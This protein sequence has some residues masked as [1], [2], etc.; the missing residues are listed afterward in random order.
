MAGT[1]LITAANSSLA[2][3]AVQHLLTQYPD[4]TAVLTVRNATDADVN[5]QRL[6][7][8]IAKCPGSKTSIHQLD[9]ADLSAVHRFADTVAD[10]IVQ[11]SLP[12]LS[13]LVCNAYYWNLA[14]GLETTGDGYEKGIQVSHI[15]H[16]ALV[17]RLLGHFGPNGGRVVLLSSETHWQGKNGMEKYPPTI[18]DDLELLA[19]PAPDPT[20]DNRGRGFQ[21][22][23][24][25]KLAIVIWMYALNRHL[26][27]VSHSFDIPTERN[28]TWLITDRTRDYATS[29]LLLST[30]ALS[31]TRALCEPIRPTCWSCCL[32]SSS[33]H[34]GLCFALWIQ[35][36][37]LPP[38]LEST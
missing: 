16:A 29:R 30:L 32:N 6:R 23:A 28:A 38:K 4:Y 25:S 26:E 14:G 15:A 18:P 19:K 17:L 2:I 24:T 33:G 1:I 11:G 21:R 8:I 5:T 9:L 3:P 27:N 34:C 12:P 35:P 13:S 36:S 31:P 10:S 7:A 22:Y 20:L 37:G